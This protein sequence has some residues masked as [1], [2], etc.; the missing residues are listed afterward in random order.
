MAV[1]SGSWTGCSHAQVR[2]LPGAA[3]R[4]SVEPTAAAPPPPLAGPPGLAEYCAARDE[5][6]A[7]FHLNLKFEVRAASLLPREGYEP[8]TLAPDELAAVGQPKIFLGHQ[9]AFFEVDL[10]AARVRPS[11]QTQGRYDVDVRLKSASAFAPRLQPLVGG[12]VAMIVNGRLILLLHLKAAPAKVS[13]LAV[14]LGLTLPEARIAAARLSPPPDSAGLQRL[15]E[16]CMG[17]ESAL[18][19]PLAEERMVGWDTPYDAERAVA[20]FEAGCR[21]GVGTACKRAADLARDP[22]HAAEL[23]E[24]GCRLNHPDACL[25]TAARLLDG[26]AAPD[27][28]AKGRAILTRL[29]D[30]RFGRAC[31]ALEE[32]FVH[33]FPDSAPPT[34]ES[35]KAMVGLIERGCTG[36]DADACFSMARVARRGSIGPTDASAAKRWMRAGCALDPSGGSTEVEVKVGGADPALLEA[37]KEAGCTGDL[38]P[39]APP[40]SLCAPAAKR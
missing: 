37:M 3:G 16:R 17:G 39:P 13:V 19:L 34:L 8:R 24:S 14:A 4:A 32:E 38:A 35:Q 23:L 9:S 26:A 25:E 2:V 7:A 5:G 40:P 6:R 28:R 33:D 20:L 21:L 12:L 30:Q 31:V 1:L 22:Q 36:G 10:A 15:E 18:C 29:C 27:S 11:W